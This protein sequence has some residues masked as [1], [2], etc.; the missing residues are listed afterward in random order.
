M[1]RLLTAQVSSSRVFFSS[2]V[3]AVY[4][5]LCA[6]YAQ[7]WVAVTLLFFWGG[8]MGGIYA[9]GLT[10]IGERFCQQDQMSA[11]MSHTIMDS[12]GGITGLL[13]I[14]VMFDWIGAEGMTSVFIACG[15]SLLVFFVHQLLCEQKTFD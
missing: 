11:N 14:G 1:Q 2:V 5:P 6:V 8:A 12:L 15:S 4:L 3:C 9:I 7:Y 10:A 13:V